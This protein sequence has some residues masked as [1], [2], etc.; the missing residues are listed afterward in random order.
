M[1]PIQDDYVSIINEEMFYRQRLPMMCARELFDRIHRLFPDECESVTM[2]RRLMGEAYRR[3]NEADALRK[4][5]A[6]LRES[7]AS[8][9]P[10]RKDGSIKICELQR[11]FR[12]GYNQ[13]RRIADAV[14]RSTARIMAESNESEAS[15]DRSGEATND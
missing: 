13:A 3:L 9:L 2:L 11:K 5:N 7:L 10:L 6:E 1:E 4:E 12:L 8:I 15:H 14:D